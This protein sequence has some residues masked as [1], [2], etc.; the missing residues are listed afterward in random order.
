MSGTAVAAQAGAVV[1]NI[2]ID[3]VLCEIGAPTAVTP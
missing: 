3:Y 1:S 2:S